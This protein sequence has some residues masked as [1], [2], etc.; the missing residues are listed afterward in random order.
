M[1]KKLECYITQGWKGLQGRNTQAY[2]AHL[3]VTKKIKGC[4]TPPALL[5]G[6]GQFWPIVICPTVIW[7]NVIW[8]N[9]IWLHVIWPN[10]IW[11]NVI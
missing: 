9:V 10:V 2:R 6:P 8:P 5:M 3:Q 7:P 1:P 11:P 4:E